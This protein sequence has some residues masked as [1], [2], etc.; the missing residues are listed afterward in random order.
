MILVTK[1]SGEMEAFTSEKLEKSLRSAGAGEQLVQ[2]IVA[3]ILDWIY[4]GVT[5]KK[6]YARAFALLRKKKTVAA[7]RYNLKQ[8]ILELGPTG[9]P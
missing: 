4:E 8:A 3:D 7:M 2:E 6:I 5:T 9:Y 1:A